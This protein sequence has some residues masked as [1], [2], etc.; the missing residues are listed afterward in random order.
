MRG[1]KRLSFGAVLVLSVV[2]STIMASRAEANSH[3]SFGVVVGAPVYAQPYYPAPTYYGLAPV[4]VAPPP[5]YYF[6]PVSYA[7][8]PATTCRAR[9]IAGRGTARTMTTNLPCCT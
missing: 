7:P 4:Y 2:A 5:S 8:P 9:T 3:I 6:P 1:V